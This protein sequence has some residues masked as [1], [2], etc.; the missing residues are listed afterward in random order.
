[1]K[2]SKLN[3]VRLAVGRDKSRSNA[4][5]LY[6]SP[7]VKDKY[8]NVIVFA[9]IERQINTAIRS[10]QN[11]YS[12][13]NGKAVFQQK[14]ASM[15][16]SDED[17]KKREINNKKSIIESGIESFAK[18]FMR[19]WT[20]RTDKSEELRAAVIRIWSGKY[21]NKCDTNNLQ[22]L[23]KME[24]KDDTPPEQFSRGLVHY[25]CQKRIKRALRRCYIPDKEKKEKYDIQLIFENLIM[26]R[27][28]GE[29]LIT[30]DELAVFADRIEKDYYKSEQS[31]KIAKSIR[32]KDVRVQ[33]E[34]GDGG[35][36]EL[37]LASAANSKDNSEQ[38]IKKRMVYDFIR[39][40]ACL[41]KEGQAKELQHIRWLI[42]RFVCGKNIYGEEE[43]LIAWQWGKYLPGS[44]Q[45]FCEK[46]ASAANKIK[47]LRNAKKFGEV[48]QTFAVI[49]AELEFQIK[50]N[51]RKIA[52]ELKGTKNGEMDCF[53][54][55][56]FQ[57]TVTN[58][59]FTKKTKE[60]KQSTDFSRK[61]ERAYL[62]SLLFSEWV[63]YVA[64][65]YI[66]MG[67]AVYH[68]ATP[69]PYAVRGKESA[70]GEVQKYF[71]HGISSFDYERIKA[72]ETLSRD[73]SVSATYA[74]AVFGRNAVKDEYRMQPE[75]EDVLQYKADDWNSATDPLHSDAVRRLLQFFGG[76]SNCGAVAE[77][78]EAL[79]LVKAV[80]EPI[81][82]IRNHSYHYAPEV[83][84]LTEGREVAEALFDMEYARAGRVVTDK[85]YSNNVYMFYPEDRV[86][87]VLDKLYGRDNAAVKRPEQV[88]A[89]AKVVPWGGF[90][91]SIADFG[92]DVNAEPLTNENGAAAKCQASVYF[93]LKEIYYNAFL[94]EKDEV[95]RKYFD[96]VIAKS[97]DAISEEKRKFEKQKNNKR[98]VVKP[99][100]YF[101]LKS[102]LERVNAMKG[103]SFSDICQQIM[104]DINLQNQGDMRVLTAEDKQENETKGQK[105]IFKNYD[106][107][108][109]DT[110]KKA[111]INYVKEFREYDFIREPD[112]YFLGDVPRKEDFCSGWQPACY[113]TVSELV[114]T[115]SL[116][117]AWYVTAHF[118]PPKQLNLLKGDI[119]SYCQYVKNINHRAKITHNREDKNIENN[120]AQYGKI[121][122]VLDFVA[123]FAGRISNTITDYYNGANADEAKAEQEKHLNLYFEAGVLD[124]EEAKGLF[125]DT[126]DSKAIVDRRVI[127]SVMFGMENV[128]KDVIKKISQA[129]LNEFREKEKAQKGSKPQCETMAEQKERSEY[130]RLKNRILLQDV[131]SYSEMIMDHMG[132]MV[133]LAYLRERDLMYFQL[134]MYYLQLKYGSLPEKYHVLSEGTSEGINITKGALLY[135]IMAVYTPDLP[136]Y[137]LVNG[138]AKKA[139]MK[140]AGSGVTTF[141]TGYCKETLTNPLTFY[142]GMG[143]FAKINSDNDEFD[144]NADLR[145]SFDHMKYLSGEGKSILDYYS[146]IYNGFFRYDTKLRKSIPFLIGNIMKRY[147]V[148]VELSFKSGEK[149][150]RNIGIS[151]IKSVSFEYKKFKESEKKEDRTLAAKS[152][153]FV[154]GAKK[155]LEYKMPEAKG[156]IK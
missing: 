37:V 8:N 67:K 40:F 102:F 51:Y 59:F 113:K 117:M 2:I 18:S 142:H 54:L 119:R 89:F 17:R 125:A 70:F 16:E 131:L 19:E 74:A 93:L 11:T 148:E 35:V 101:A 129:E 90:D 48:K 63:S 154:E 97:N 96:E 127:F 62:S 95:I 76:Q 98:K 30:D 36:P 1:M 45:K 86:R 31:E 134:G 149:G 139:D 12:I 114:K 28:F 94:T 68:F 50:D 128:I 115:D 32:H 58:L 132:Q 25:I 126:G 84:Q 38:K 136:L 13:F 79:E 82:I 80:R 5:F 122:S 152:K 137:K 88:P 146:D 21:G 150:K 120:I 121:L 15:Y 155:L 33:V 153:T 143:L 130:T 43:E 3:H 72:E 41:D 138:L 116:A 44:G 112:C 118:L 145:K 55:K 69:D 42:L 100:E 75:K 4:G 99:K 53:W 22:T 123:L 141:V 47:D 65:K 56:Y 9:D 61:L 57:R 77:K 107:H 46:A 156:A 39:R 110:I 34:K 7:P 109:K 73:L 23:R 27:L 144:L 83:G 140:T 106:F 71:T 14:K 147:F 29:Q 81:S 78:Y 10:A 105:E 49:K 91:K 85:Y 60:L 108:L 87:K 26:S 92:L 104:T 64:M 20:R 6:N 66:D 133:S 52:D 24:G 135:Q 124:S 103:M 151:S 111:F